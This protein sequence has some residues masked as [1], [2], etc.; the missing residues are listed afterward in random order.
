VQFWAVF[1]TM[2]QIAALSDAKWNYE[3]WKM[4]C[5]D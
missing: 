1:P 4:A 2:E 5:N 3:I